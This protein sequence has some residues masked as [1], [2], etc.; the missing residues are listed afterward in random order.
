MEPAL[1]LILNGYIFH[2]V[3][4]LS[5]TKNTLE[6]RRP[7][8]GTVCP[9][10]LPSFVILPLVPALYAQKD[11]QAVLKGRGRGLCEDPAYQ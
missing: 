10:P 3:I 2:V 11:R 4:S 1:H 5:N 9:I 6:Y 8:E 7:L